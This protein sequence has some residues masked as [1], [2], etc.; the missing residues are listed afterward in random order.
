MRIT[1]NGALW[2]VRSILFT[3]WLLIFVLDHKLGGA[4]C[5]TF[6]HSES[7]IGYWMS[8]NRSP[9]E[10]TLLGTIIGNLAAANWWAFVYFDFAES[11]WLGRRARKILGAFW[12]IAPSREKSISWRYRLRYLAVGISALIPDGGLLS[13]LLVAVALRL[14]RWRVLPVLLVGN[15]AKNLGAGWFFSFFRHHPLLT[16][17]LAIAALGASV[18][19]AAYKFAEQRIR[20]RKDSLK[21]FPFPGMG[22]E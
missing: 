6:F 3:A 12:D 18:I 9:L 2:A 8:H 11:T 14:N 10:A 16:R 7:A 1:L 13:G 21:K 20:A 5:W 22:M 4:L 15:T 19:V 17:E